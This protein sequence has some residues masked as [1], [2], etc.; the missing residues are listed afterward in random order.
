MEII[1]AAHV[2]N[3]VFSKAVHKSVITWDWLWCIRW[4]PERCAFR[5]REPAVEPE[6]QV[7]VSGRS[8]FGQADGTR[9]VPATQSS[10]V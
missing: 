3:L 7:A 9:A 1:N 6:D 2:T 10:R 5:D 4:S 8:R